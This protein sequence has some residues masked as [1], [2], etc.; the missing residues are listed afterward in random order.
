MPK[1]QANG[2][3]VYYEAQGNGEP[4][5]LIAGFGCDHTHWARVARTLAGRFRVV[6]FDNRGVGRTTGGETL[7][8]IRQMADDAARLIDALDLG[9]CH[10][11]GHSMGGLVAQELA[12]AHPEQIRSLMLLSSCARNDARGKAIVESWGDLPRQVDALT[13]TKLILPWIYTRAFFARPG[14]IEQVIEHILANP[15]PPSVDV[16]HRQSRAIVPCD[17]SD[18]LG[19]IACPTLVLV[20]SQDILLPVAFSEELARGIRGAELVVLEKTGHGLLIESPD[21]VAAAMLDFLS[22]QQPAQ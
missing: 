12:L 6:A 16:I 17:T 13:A 18:R 19:A 22:R 5:L 10:V 11:A 3:D 9:P 8:S 21:A 1:V 2:I 4:V 15:F 7:V 20:G 14:A